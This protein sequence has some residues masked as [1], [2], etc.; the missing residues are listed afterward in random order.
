MLTGLNSLNYR[1]GICPD[2]YNGVPT[3]SKERKTGG[4]ALDP[5]NLPRN[6]GGGAAHK[7]V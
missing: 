3:H 4:N 2:L 1:R 5:E 6:G 7:G